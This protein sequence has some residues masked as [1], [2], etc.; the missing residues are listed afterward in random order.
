M[1]KRSAAA[2]EPEPESVAVEPTATADATDLA[3]LFLSLRPEPQVRIVPKS[4]VIDGLLDLRIAATA[5]V[6]I[7]RIDRAI[8][9]VPGRTTT[10]A[11]WWCEQ[12]DLLELLTGDLIASPSFAKP[13]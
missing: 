8:A 1:R 13:H 6:F 7:D 11:D 10:S 5:P 9:D 4:E 2:N 3:G 12:L